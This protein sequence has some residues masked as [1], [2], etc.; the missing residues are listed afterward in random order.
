MDNNE[1]KLTAS[2]R[3]KKKYYERIKN[4]PNYK[5]RRNTPEI[6]AKLR[7]NSKKYYNKIKNNEEFKIKVSEKKREY[8]NRKKAE[9]FF[10]EIQL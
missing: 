3:A 4:D 5:A 6:K 1:I 9:T 8:Y 2:Q 7:E 10:L